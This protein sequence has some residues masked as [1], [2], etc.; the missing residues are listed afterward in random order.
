[1]VNITHARIDKGLSQKELADLMGVSAAAVSQWESGGKRPQKANLAKLAEVLGVST[2]YL[3]GKE[4]NPFQNVEGIDRRIMEIIKSL[5]QRKKVL[6]L[7][8]LVGL[9]AS[10]EE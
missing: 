4:E 9:S 3:L 10:S 7:Q 6:L 2:E 1:M 5:S 8:Y